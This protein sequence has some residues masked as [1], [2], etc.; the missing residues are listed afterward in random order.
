MAKLTLLIVSPQGGGKGTATSH[1]KESFGADSC[2]FSTPIRA[3]C[4]ALGIPQTR[5]ELQKFA[6]VMRKAYGQDF[7]Q[8]AMM[9]HCAASDADIMLIDGARE[10]GDIDVLMHDP[11]A[12]MLSIETDKSIRKARLTARGENEGEAEMTDAEFEATESHPNERGIAEMIAWVGDRFP[13]KLHAVD[14]NGDWSET[15]AAID[16][17][18]DALLAK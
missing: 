18:V 13:E 11:S 2:R 17:V 16:V 6:Q 1:V 7:W 9:A 8:K 3:G 15:R 5:E 12:H 14:N 10:I 4:D